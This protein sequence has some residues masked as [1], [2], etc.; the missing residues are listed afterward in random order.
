MRGPHQATLWHNSLLSLVLLAANVGAPFR[1][2]DLVRHFLASP[3]RTAS[4][5]PIVR[6]RAVSSAG[7]T[8][9]FRA[10]VGVAKGGPDAAA[11]G[12]RLHPSA[13]LWR[14]LSDV[15]PARQVGPPVAR[16]NPPLRC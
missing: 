10:V 15:L 8:Q 13:A 16:Q 1:S 11:P 6:V 4:A 14:S 5:A 2:A 9:G 3:L 12:A 7:V